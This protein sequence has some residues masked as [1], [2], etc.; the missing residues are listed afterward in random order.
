[1]HIHPSIHTYIHT[2]IHTVYISSSLSSSSSSARKR[3]GRVRMP[4]TPHAHSHIS[5][6]A[7]CVSS[8]QASSH[9]AHCYG[10]LCAPCHEAAPPLRRFHLIFF[11]STPQKTTPLRFL[12][13][14]CVVL[15]RSFPLMFPRSPVRY[16]L[17]FRVESSSF[18]LQKLLLSS[19]R[20]P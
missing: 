14:S 10:S 4:P 19:W 8:P 6:P 17:T 5:L 9:G 3:R 18:N 12:K 2:Y 20:F 7:S 16:L 13:V 15:P 11:V 1:M